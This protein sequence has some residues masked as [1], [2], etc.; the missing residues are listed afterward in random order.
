MKRILIVVF[1][2]MVLASL[3]SWAQT[4]SQKGDKN[5]TATSGK[6]MTITGTV[7]EDG[8]M[9]V[10]DKDNKSWKVDNPETLKQHA[11]HHVS[12]TAN[13]DPSTD[14]LHVDSVKMLG[15]GKSGSPS[16]SGENGNKSNKY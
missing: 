2:V 10:S 4:S 12:V 3:G 9:I 8:K 1:S 6:T 15:K 14:T 13:A 5:S 16:N 7:S 11:G